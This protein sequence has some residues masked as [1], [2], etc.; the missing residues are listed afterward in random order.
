VGDTPP[1]DL[2]SWPD[3]DLVRL[4]QMRSEAAIAIAWSAF[5]T[6][7][8]RHV[9]EV[10]NTVYVC[11]LRSFFLSDQNLAAQLTHEAFLKAWDALPEKKAQAP[12]IAWIKRIAI[13]E[14]R[15]HQ[16]KHR[17][18]TSLTNDEEQF[19]DNP[20]S[21]E[22]SP[23]EQAALQDT[24]ERIL[25]CLTEQERAVFT[26][27]H[28]GYS[29]EEIAAILG[30]KV[31]SVR[32]ELWRAHGHFR[33]E[34]LKEASAGDS[35]PSQPGAKKGKKPSNTAAQPQKTANPPT[36]RKKRGRQKP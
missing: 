36:T 4:A 8:H 26:L 17:R 7:Y 16:R 32:Q 13:N 2:D 5:T 21:L 28:Q 15:Q 14:A 22:Q 33:K 29:Q 24:I 31:T 20:D 11:L 25:M 3:V 30:I 6:L 35:P 1:G 27:H 34:W 12:F 19:I 23:E 10:V 18:E 9:T